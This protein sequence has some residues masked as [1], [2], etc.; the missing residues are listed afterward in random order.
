[1]I[2]TRTSSSARRACGPTCRSCS[3]AK[4]HGAVITSEMEAFFDVCPC[5]IIGVTGSDG[6]TT[7]TSVIAELLK[8][9]GRRV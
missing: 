5:T 1:M 9:E 2:W 4:A 3:E 7:T 8:A 6:K